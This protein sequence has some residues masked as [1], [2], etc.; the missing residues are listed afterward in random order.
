MKNIIICGT[1]GTGKATISKKLSKEFKLTYLNDWQLFH[2]MG[3]GKVPSSKVFSKIMF[4]FLRDKEKIV[5]DLDMSI[6]PK[7]YRALNFDCMVYYIGFVSVDLKTL[8]QKL[9]EGDIQN[10]VMAKR[11]AKYLLKCGKKLCRECKKYNLPFIE[12][13]EDKDKA[14]KQILNTIREE[15]K[16]E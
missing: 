4:E 3:M 12:I 16:G 1:V 6:M 15:I 5:L 8:T 11:K 14:I 10:M 7:D 9:Y 2:E 13:K